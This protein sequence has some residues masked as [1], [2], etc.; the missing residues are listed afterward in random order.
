MTAA[1]TPEQLLAHHD[2]GTPWPEDDLNRPFKAAARAARLPPETT[3]YSLRHYHISKAL[4]AGVQPQVVA[5]NCGTSLR[6]IEKHYGKFLK[7]DR[8]AMF[9]AV[10]L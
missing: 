9:N 3:F 4:L 1:L 7:A 8:R 2:D 10:A 5:E 6:M